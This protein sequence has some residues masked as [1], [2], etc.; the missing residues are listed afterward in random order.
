MKYRVYF[1][2]TFNMSTIDYIVRNTVMTSK[3]EDALSQYN[4]SRNHDG[5]KPLNRL[6]KGVKFVAIN[7]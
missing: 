5:L 3:E 2:L 6:P 4:H 7:E 1:P